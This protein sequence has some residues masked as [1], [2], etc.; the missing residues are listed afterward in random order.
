MKIINSST[1]D[2]SQVKYIIFQ[3]AVIIIL[4]YLINNNHN[5]TYKVFDIKEILHI[6]APNVKH[7]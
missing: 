1:G 4:A 3:L 6:F 5:F 2:L 7:N